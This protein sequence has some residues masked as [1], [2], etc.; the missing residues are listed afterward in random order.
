MA[1][2]AGR[3]DDAIEHYRRCLEYGDQVLVVP[4]Q[5][6]ITGHVSITGMAQAC[7]QK[8][9]WAMA[10]HLLERSI[11]MCPEW[12]VSILT[13]SR[14][15][16]HQRDFDRAVQVLT[17]YLAEHPNSAGACSQATVMLGKLGMTEQARAIGE[18]AIVLLERSSCTADAQRMK[19]T[20]A[21]LA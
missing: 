1:L 13:L 2:A 5:E 6:G 17:E 18:R 15:H 16:F 12:E 20:V 11:A 10:R 3:N 8:G 9:D 7:L 21:A 4:I 19:E 14:L